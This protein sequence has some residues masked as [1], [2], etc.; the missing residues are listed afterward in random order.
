M[1]TKLTDWL[2]AG[3]AAFLMAL[4]PMHGRAAEVQPDIQARYDARAAACDAAMVF[5]KTARDPYPPACMQAATIAGEA[6]RQGFEQFY[7]V[8]VTEKQR[9]TFGQ[10]LAVADAQAHSSP[11][12]AYDSIMPALIVQLRGQLTDRQLFALWKFERSD[13][14]DVYPY[15][16]AMMS[17]AMQMLANTY[18]YRP[19]PIYKLTGNQ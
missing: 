18:A 2:I 9:L 19:D 8:F 10:M 13:I 14:R 7:D 5:V 11:D 1:K 3:L 6:R 16:W 17:E 4:I 15:A 12:A